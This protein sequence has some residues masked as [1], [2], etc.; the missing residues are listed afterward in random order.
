[1]EDCYNFKRLEFIRRR[2]RI[3]PGTMVILGPQYLSGWLA[4]LVLSLVS[5]NT[6]KSGT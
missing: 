2:V 3:V 1:M 6:Q 5:C 4:E